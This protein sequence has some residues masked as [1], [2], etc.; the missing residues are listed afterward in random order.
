MSGTKHGPPETHKFNYIYM[1]KP[2]VSVWK[3]KQTDE[4]LSAHP[5]ENQLLTQVSH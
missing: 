3:S 1:W 4:V 2:K 5:A